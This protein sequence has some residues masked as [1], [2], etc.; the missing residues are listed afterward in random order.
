[1][2]DGYTVRVRQ[3]SLIEWLLCAKSVGGLINYEMLLVCT[4]HPSV[5]SI[6][7]NLSV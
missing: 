3:I 6:M 2:Q 4:T 1:V 5:P 7:H